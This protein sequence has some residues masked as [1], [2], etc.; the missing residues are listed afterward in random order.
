MQNAV[1]KWRKKY[2][3]VYLLVIC[4]LEMLILGVGIAHDTKLSH[5]FVHDN[6]CIMNNNFQQ[7]G[8]SGVFSVF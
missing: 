8:I 6:D 7:T 3:G 1:K 4:S 5:Y 2:L